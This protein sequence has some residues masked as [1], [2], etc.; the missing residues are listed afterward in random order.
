MFSGLYKIIN[1]IPFYIFAASMSE[2][3]NNE[4]KK[5]NNYDPFTSNPSFANGQTSI[6]NSSL[7]SDKSNLTFFNF[8]EGL[9]LKYKPKRYKVLYKNDLEKLQEY[10]SET[11]KHLSIY[12]ENISKDF[13]DNIIMLFKN[14]EV[15]EFDCY[16]CNRKQNDLQFNITDS[17]ETNQTE[18]IKNTKEMANHSIKL[19]IFNSVF[20]NNS[21]LSFFDGFVRL[22]YIRFNDCLFDNYLNFL[23]LSVMKRVKS[24]SFERSYFGFFLFRQICHLSNIRYLGIKINKECFKSI[25]LSSEDVKSSF[26]LLGENILGLI[27]DFCDLK[28]PIL[29]LIGTSCTCLQE[30]SINQNDNL[31]FDSNV[32]YKFFT[33][34]KCLSCCHCTNFN[35][36]YA[37]NFTNLHYLAFNPFDSL[38]SKNDLNQYGQA[39]TSLKILYLDNILS[40]IKWWQIL[41]LFKNIKMLGLVIELSLPLSPIPND[42]LSILKTIEILDIRNFEQ[43]SLFVSTVFAKFSGLKCL[44]LRGIVNDELLDWFKFQEALNLEV[45]DIH[46]YTCAPTAKSFNKIHEIRSLKELKIKCELSSGESISFL[47]TLNINKGSNKPDLHQSSNTQH[48]FIK[49]Q[50]E[51]TISTDIKDNNK[52]NLIIKYSNEGK[53]EILIEEWSY[54]AVEHKKRVNLN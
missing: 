2:K 42:D 46:S 29:Q 39:F 53:V 41:P 27:L 15:L 1:I 26:K 18:N 50:V 13:L 38:F 52:S 12:I 43:S 35:L 51:E 31:N 34:I 45:L 6:A 5:L 9:E 23:T 32:I 19:L 17:A 3:A 11:I 48:E 24:L 10:G 7:N 47:Q 44:I 28:E 40:T 20:L 4:C 37:S 54:D 8:E 16:S 14:L 30:L 21:L 36:K 33:T 49:N 22:Q 25:N